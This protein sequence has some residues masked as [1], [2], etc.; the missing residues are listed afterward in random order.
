MRVNLEGFVKK[1]G[2]TI[3]TCVGAAGVVGTAILTS[4]GT[5][6]ANKLL[7]E[8]R[9]EK[10]ADLTLIETIKYATPSYIPAILMGTGT[11]ACII[12]ANILNKQHQASLMSAYVLLDQSY[13]EY[14]NKVEA[15]YGKEATQAVEEAIEKDH[16]PR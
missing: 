6:K 12:G 9:K 7:E 1:N 15:L 4:R 11:V 8:A 3:L 10:E 14:R 5:T 2:A 16:C 13:K